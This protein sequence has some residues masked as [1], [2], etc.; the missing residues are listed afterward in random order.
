MVI[1][2]PYSRFS[3][4][5]SP[6]G[7]YEDNYNGWD[8]FCL[9][10]KLYKPFR[11]EIIKALTSKFNFSLSI[12][13]RIAC[14]IEIRFQLV[15]PDITERAEVDFYD[16]NKSVINMAVVLYIGS[17]T[18]EF[19][20]FKFLKIKTNDDDDKLD[21][22]KDNRLILDLDT[23]KQLNDTVASIAGTHRTF[24]LLYPFYEKNDV[25]DS[26]TN[27]PISKNWM[28]S[29]I[30]Y[31]STGDYRYFVNG[32]GLM[33]ELF[34][35]KDRVYDNIDILE[36]FSLNREKFSNVSINEY[37]GNN[38]VYKTPKE[39]YEKFTLI[40]I[41]FLQRAYIAGIIPINHVEGNNFEFIK[42]WDLLPS[43]YD[44]NYQFFHPYENIQDFLEDEKNGYLAKG[45]YDNT[46]PIGKIL[47]QPTWLDKRIVNY[48]EGATNFLLDR[49]FLYNKEH[50]DNSFIDTNEYVVNITMSNN[51]VIRHYVAKDLD[52]Y[53]ENLE[54]SEGSY[55]YF[56]EQCL[57]KIGYSLGNGEDI[58]DTEKNRL[59]ILKALNYENIQKI[60]AICENAI[61]ESE[62]EVAIV[63]RSEQNQLNS[64]INKLINDDLIK[65]N[66]Y[67]IYEIA[68]PFNP[69]VLSI[70]F[71]NDVN[72]N[73]SIFQE[74]LDNSYLQSNHQ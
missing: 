71:D 40:G 31:M 66:N 42:D 22:Y 10:T 16:Y 30:P 38:I 37:G 57:L 48:Y 32:Q 68:D 65:Y 33:A 46:T 4:G 35:P 43:D 47:Y 58:K 51:R 29:I 41:D 3:T 60:L 5:D 14:K 62:G 28:N 27:K 61:D 73:V 25:Y 59:Q 20:P 6:D 50:I 7:I 55:Y 18:V 74:V 36:R 52:E 23:E 9:K 13:E 49:L 19:L 8:L 34:S 15:K 24:C 54:D 64:V 69:W 70:N 12:A 63:K 67:V 1:L 26:N 72:I 2:T 45:I 21:I 44:E 11:K 56:F 53:F 39:I 17:K